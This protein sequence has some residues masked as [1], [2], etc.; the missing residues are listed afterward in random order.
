MLGAAAFKGHAEIVRAL[1]AVEGVEVNATDDGDYPSTA[2]M[3]AKER[4]HKEAV[5]AL[6]ACGGK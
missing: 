6:L 2:L 4:G 5:D 3:L 1:L